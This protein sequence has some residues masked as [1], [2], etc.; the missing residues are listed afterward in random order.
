VSAGPGLYGL[1]AEYATPRDLV[2]GIE[3]VRAAGHRRIDAFTPYPVDA[4]IEALGARSTRLPWLVLAGGVLG[5]AGVFALQWWISAV[6]YPLDVGGRP[7]FSWP[8]FVVPAFEGTILGA[9]LAAVLGLFAL[10][11]LPMPYHPVFNVERFA[12]ASRDR[13]FLL[14]E[15]RDP[16][17]DADAT[18]RLLRG[19]PAVEV[20]DVAP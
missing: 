18:R 8:A 13:F 19:T 15:A 14:V 1:L 17:F 3:A 9:A 4:V 6:D 7:P 20:S 2:R 12:L 5:G 16:R 10:N 11:G